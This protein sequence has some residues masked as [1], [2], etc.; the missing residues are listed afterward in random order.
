MLQVGQ[1]GEFRGRQ[2][3]TIGH[4]YY[5]SIRRPTVSTWEE[6]L[7][8]FT[9]GTHGYLVIVDDDEVSYSTQNKQTISFSDIPPFTQINVGDVLPF[10]RHNLT[11]VEKG[12][13]QV[14]AI[15]G[16]QVTQS[17]LLGQEFHY[18]DAKFH[19]YLAHFIYTSENL[20]LY[21]GV[22]VKP[23]NLLISPR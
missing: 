9:D 15:V 1:S 22:E 10:N 14:M 2:F 4:V 7:I 16:Q 11:I 13:A 12:A 21:Y 17:T 3:T 8:K 19:T 20:H 5:Q 18:I 6:W 23:E